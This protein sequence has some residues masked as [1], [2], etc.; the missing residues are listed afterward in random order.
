MVRNKTKEDTIEF[1]IVQS[2]KQ[3]SFKFPDVFLECRLKEN[4]HNNG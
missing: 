3:R 1:L 4:S 2:N